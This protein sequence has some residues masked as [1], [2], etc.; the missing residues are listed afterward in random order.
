MLRRPP[1]STRTHTLFPYTT[2]FRSDRLWRA[3]EIRRSRLCVRGRGRRVRLRG[4]IPEMERADA[5]HRPREQ[6]LAG[7]RAAPRRDQ[8]RADPPPRPF[9]GRARRRLDAKRRSLARQTQGVPPVT[10]H[11][12][13]P[14]RAQFDA[15]KALPRDTVI[16]MLNLVRFRDK[17]A[18]PPDHPPA[19]PGLRGPEAYR[20]EERR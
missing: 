11:H 12:I 14:E 8:Q 16:H 5:Q 6:P 13:D 19:G 18:Y 17:A 10:D 9:P 3:R 7:A 4:R 1:S 2:R 15:F 20:P